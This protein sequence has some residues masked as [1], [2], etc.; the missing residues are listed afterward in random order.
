[1]QSRGSSLDFELAK[2]GSVNRPL[3]DWKKKHGQ[4]IDRWIFVLIK[5]GDRLPIYSGGTAR[6]LHD[7]SQGVSHEEAIKNFEDHVADTQQSTDLDKMSDFQRGSALARTATLFMSARLSLLRGEMRAIRQVRR[8]KIDKATFI[9]RMAI[10]HVIIPSL[11]QMVASGWEFDTEDQIV[12]ITLGQLNTFLNV[13]DIM[14][15]QLTTLVTGESPPSWA[16]QNPIVETYKELMNG[17]GGLLTSDFEQEEVMSSLDDIIDSTT[18]IF[19]VPTQ[20]KNAIVGGTEIIDDKIV[21]GTKQILGSSPKVAGGKD[22][23]FI[24]PNF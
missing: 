17:F 2:I 13:G 24:G 10:Y 23:G 12:A 22:R 8:G 1:M 3:S 4:T 21:K 19:G 6:Y 18:K 7:I 15:S 14:Y 9:R 20:I 16:S 5:G 11:V